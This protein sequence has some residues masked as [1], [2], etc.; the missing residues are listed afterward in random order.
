MLGTGSKETPIV[1]VPQVAKNGY[2][3]HMIKIAQ[4]DLALHASL[5]LP[6]CRHVG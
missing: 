5:L 3:H 1:A 2:A 4:G 6:G